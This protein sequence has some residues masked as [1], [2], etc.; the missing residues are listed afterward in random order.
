VAAPA[1]ARLLLME[2][3]LRDTVTLLNPPIVEKELFDL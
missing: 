2:D 1:L 3:W